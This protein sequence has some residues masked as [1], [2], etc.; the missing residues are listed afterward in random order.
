MATLAI[1]G[2]GEGVAADDNGK[3]AGAALVDFK[4]DHILLR[5]QGRKRGGSCCPGGETG[6]CLAWRLTREVP[7]QFI[8]LS[9]GPQIN[10]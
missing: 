6:H 8:R 3:G 4:K 5:H 10:R 1:W 2:G 7:P 9:T